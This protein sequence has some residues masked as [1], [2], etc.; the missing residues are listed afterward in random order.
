MSR[1]STRVSVFAGLLSATL[2][3][4]FA[5]SVLLHNREGMQEQLAKALA[6]E[7]RS[8][9]TRLGAELESHP[10]GIPAPVVRDLMRPL[11]ATG[12]LAQLTGPDGSELFASPGFPTSSEGFQSRKETLPVGTS[13]AYALELARTTGD[14]REQE[15]RLALFFVLFEQFRRFGRDAWEQCLGFEVDELRADR[16]ELG[17][18][19]NMKAL[20][21]SDGAQILIR[22]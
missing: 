9:L 19:P 10:E 3:G 15:L 14:L 17:Q 5:T 12:S 1:L 2:L 7:S 11:E 8:L 20:A 16:H 6:T 4:V 18:R 22:H 13:G 21:C